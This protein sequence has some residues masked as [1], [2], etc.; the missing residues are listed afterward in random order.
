MSSLFKFNKFFY[1]IITVIALS[2]LIS[3]FT[4][5]NTIL[6]P[7][8]LSNFYVIKLS[9]S[10]QENIYFNV[11]ENKLVATGKT[12]CDEDSC[13]PSNGLPYIMEYDFKS[14]NLIEI[15]SN[16]YR[17][18]K[19]TNGDFSSEGFQL[20]NRSLTPKNGDL[21][22]FYVKKGFLEYTLN[23]VPNKTLFNN[24]TIFLG[25]KVL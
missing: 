8:Q 9:G 12:T 20:L 14:K 21:E 25:W 10:K 3:G 6:S 18:M 1:F 19:L 4:I 15:D 23:I 17:E 5:Y 11:Q 24:K 7:S 16:K 2:L 22:E 13:S